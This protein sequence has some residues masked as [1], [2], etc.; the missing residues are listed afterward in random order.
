MTTLLTLVVIG[1][2]AVVAIFLAKGYRLS[3]DT[4]TVSGTGILS[5]T[6]IPDQASVYLDGHLTTATNDNINSLPPKVYKV[7]IVKEGFIPWEKDEE[8]KA[9]FVTDVKATLFRSIP[10]IYPLTYTGAVNPVLSPDGQKLIYEVPVLQNANPLELKRAGLWVWQMSS[11]RA[12]SL[13][14]GAEPHQIAQ[15]IPGL[16]FTKGQFKWSPDSSQVMVTFADRVLLLDT[17]RFNDLPKDITATAGSTNKQWENDQ[18]AKDT[19]RLALIKDMGIRKEASSAAFLKWAPDDSKFMY[20]KDG[21]DNFKVVNLGAGKDAVSARQVGLP[22]NK[23][24]YSWLADSDHLIL[25]ETQSDIPENEISLGGIPGKISILEYD[26]FN[27]SE[28]YAGNFN[29]DAVF[30]WPDSSRLVI[31]SSVPT[32]TASEPNLFGINLK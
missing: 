19:V 29:P 4:K 9:G 17:N 26:G 23:G 11:E 2:S 15:N 8:V 7:R 30:A 6:S 25:V 28:I 12:I 5:I 31:L 18:K 22:Q 27:K 10:S 13:N 21:K 1:L 3:P 32:A 16:D 20:S 14:R 24:I